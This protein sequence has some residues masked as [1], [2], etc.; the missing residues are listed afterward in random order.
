MDKTV[1]TYNII[2]QQFADTRIPEFY[3]D[4]FNYFQ[5]QMPKG[6]VIDIACGTGR[7]ARLFAENKNYSY[8]GIDASKEMLKIAKKDN[9]DLRF[10]LMDFNDLNFPNQLFD[11]FWM[12]AALLHI[13]KK[14]IKKVLIKLQEI[15]KRGM[16]WAAK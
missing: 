2:A 3:R 12:A 14:E 5:Q 4:E 15:M 1:Q 6:K 9:P 16:L 8:I 11:G 13:P 7:D 10:E